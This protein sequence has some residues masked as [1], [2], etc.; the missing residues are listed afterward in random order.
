VKPKK[1]G[2]GS[3]KCCRCKMLSCMLAARLCKYYADARAWYE[4]LFCQ[5]NI[6][7]TFEP[8]SMPVLTATG[9]W[10]F[11]F[12]PSDACRLAT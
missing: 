3:S 9:L 7:P 6:E 12:Q 1:A 10:L 8:G 4:R 11:D 5:T 2:F